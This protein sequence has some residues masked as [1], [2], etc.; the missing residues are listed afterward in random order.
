VDNIAL[1][2]DGRCD[3]LLFVAPPATCP[4][5]SAL[6]QNG[7]PFVVIGDLPPGS[8]I[9]GVDVN[10]REA[11]RSLVKLLV[12]QGHR[13]IAI[14]CGDSELS[15]TVQRLQGYRDAIAEAYIAVEETLVRPCGYNATAGYAH[16]VE[17]M[18]L[19]QSLRPTALFCSNDNIALGALQAI[20]KLKMRVPRDISVV[21]FDDLP[22]AAE[23]SPPLTTVRQPLRLLGERA[24]EALLARIADPGLPGLKEYLPTDLIVRNSVAPPKTDASREGAE[25]TSA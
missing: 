23:T 3:G 7:M 21:G 12:E 9:S 22:A 17:L 15:S 24:T 1:Y 16:V 19:P 20:K 13:R 25:G 4:V 18:R 2:S 8:D 5:L 6:Q 11:A 14:L 10:N